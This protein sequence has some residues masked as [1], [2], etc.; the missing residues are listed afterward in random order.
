MLESIWSVRCSSNGQPY[1]SSQ[2][3]S[4]FLA[5]LQQQM[6]HDWARTQGDIRLDSGVPLSW[7]RGRSP[8]LSRDRFNA[9]WLA[10]GAVYVVEEGGGLLVSL[11]HLVGQ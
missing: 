9:K 1:S 5:V 10:E 2:V 3:V 8:V 7:L 6:Q 11:P 4:R